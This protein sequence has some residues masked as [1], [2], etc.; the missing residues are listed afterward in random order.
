MTR[1]DELNELVAQRAGRSLCGCGSAIGAVSSPADGSIAPPETFTPGLD[2]LPAPGRVPSRAPSSICFSG[3]RS[4]ASGIIPP[5][6][7]PRNLPKK[8]AS[9]WEWKLLAR[10]RGEG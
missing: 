6:H 3:G 10:R 1:G 5:K 4:I 9:D 2:Y 8:G 7:D